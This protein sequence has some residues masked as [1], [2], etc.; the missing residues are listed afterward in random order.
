MII[1]KKAP[2]TKEEIQQLSE[3]YE[4]YIKTVIDLENKICS[5]GGVMHADN[6]KE[7][8][9]RES[10]QENLWGGG[11][12]LMTKMI[13]F[14]SLINIR[15]QDDNPSMEILD[16]DKRKRFEDLMKYFFQ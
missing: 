11:I 14:N 10:K 12:D 3:E 9:L 5:A 7:L 13:D 4:D 6:E 16:A 8:L 15:A 2:F 1:T